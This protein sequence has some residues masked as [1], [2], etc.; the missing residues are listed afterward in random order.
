MID[1]EFAEYMVAKKNR[2]EVSI[3]EALRE[4]GMLAKKNEKVFTLSGGKQQRIA[5]ARLMIKKCDIILANEPTGSLDKGNT[6]TVIDILKKLND[7][8]KTVIMVTHDEE[9]KKVGKRII[10]L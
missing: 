3:D 9:L 5:L 6:T 10:A 8:G 4:V 2:T 1:K 7:K